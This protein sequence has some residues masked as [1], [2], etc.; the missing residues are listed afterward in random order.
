MSGRPA[1]FTAA[2]NGPCHRAKGAEGHD[3][4][5]TESVGECG[6]DRGQEDLQQV[7][8]R[9]HLAVVHRCETHTS[10]Q[11]STTLLRIEFQ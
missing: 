7:V 11:R 2:K 1:S 3:L 9:L 6:G 5:P 4:H 8:D 10:A